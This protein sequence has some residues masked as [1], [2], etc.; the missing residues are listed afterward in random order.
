MTTWIKETSP[1]FKARVAGILYVLTGMA[2]IAMY[3]RSSVVV[4]GDNTSTATNILNT[5]LF[6]RF[7]FAVD[8]VAVA[9]YVGVVGI[10]YVL[11]KPVSRSLSIVAAFFGL[12]GCAT[13]TTNMI[14]HLV[15]L[16]LLDGK[17]TLTVFTS[18]Q[19]QALA[20]TFLRIHGIGFNIGMTFFGFYCFL[21]GWLIL[22]STFLPRVIGV[23]M[24][25]T[26]LGY[27]TYTFSYF[28]FPSFSTHLYPYI[29]TPGVLGE[30]GLMLWLIFVG[31]NNSKWN[32][33]AERSNLAGGFSSPA[34]KGA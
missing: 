4:P 22:G 16:Y 20:S 32:E 8:L 31:V 7:G 9:A 30:G 24:M 17:G 23:L 12:V 2:P 29:L 21:I 11:L 6:F 3:A 26:G 19:I 10:L 14:N 28:V 5:E 34:L 18:E 25:I 13:S 33:Q 27:L 15:P 1:R